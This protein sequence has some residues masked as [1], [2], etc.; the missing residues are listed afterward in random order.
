M[1]KDLKTSK[2]WKQKE[3]ETREFRRRLSEIFGKQ[4]ELDDIS[5][6]YHFVS[7][8]E[9]HNRRTPAG[10]T[11]ELKN[12]LRALRTWV[13]QQ[14]FKTR[15]MGRLGA[16]NLLRELIRRM[17]EMQ[18][19]LVKMNSSTRLEKQPKFILYSG[20]DD[21][22]LALL[23]AMGLQHYRVP[24]FAAYMVFEGHEFTN[25]FNISVMYDD[26]PLLIQCTPHCELQYFSNLMKDAIPQN[27]EDEC[28]TPTKKSLTELF[29]LS[30][31]GINI[32]E[33]NC[34]RTN[35]LVWL[36]GYACGI[37][38]YRILQCWF[39]RSLSHHSKTKMS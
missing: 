37:F 27:W 38:F 30:T 8:E 36:F 22:I 11:D 26:A 9:L 34:S 5:A 19:S 10:W 31:I 33:M 24:E 23:S 28:Q 16:G 18:E 7:F 1:R 15:E 20:H 13:L 32:S 6:L 17:S 3:I 25:Q 35:I 39:S 4:I 12:Q 2:E 14:K 29:S 21:L